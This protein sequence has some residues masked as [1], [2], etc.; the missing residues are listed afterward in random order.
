MDFN[1]S[2]HESKKFQ[3]R[4]SLFMFRNS[5]FFD[6]PAFLG[7]CSRLVLNGTVY[8]AFWKILIVT[9][10]WRKW[11]S[12]VFLLFRLILAS[13]QPVWKC[14]QNRNIKLIVHFKDSEAHF[15]CVAD[16]SSNF[17]LPI[18]H[19]F[20]LLWAITGE[21]PLFF[22]SLFCVVFFFFPCI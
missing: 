8:G 13:L 16:T 9:F 5:L 1:N 11:F 14:Y 15:G 3:T 7:I 18:T 12:L 21:T 17:C 20:L 6:P 10:L 2:F 4:S 22:L 19:L